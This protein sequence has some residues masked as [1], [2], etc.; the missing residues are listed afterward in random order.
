MSKNFQKLLKKFT[1]EVIKLLPQGPSGQSESATRFDTQ[2]LE[3][4]RGSMSTPED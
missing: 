3:N 4:S 1:V 2:E